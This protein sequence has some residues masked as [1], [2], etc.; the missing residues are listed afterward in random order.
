M[1]A[2]AATFLDYFQFHALTRP[3]QMALRLTGRQLCYR[4]VY[5]HLLR[6]V[7]V[8]RE[9]GWGRERVRVT[10]CLQDSYAQV[11]VPMACEVLGLPYGWQGS[12]HMPVSG[13]WLVSRAEDVPADVSAWVLDDGVWATV[14]TGAPVADGDRPLSSEGNRE[15]VRWLA[16]EAGQREP[17][18]I[19]RD[20]A[21]QRLGWTV[22]DGQFCQGDL[23][24]L[25]SP[26]NDEFVQHWVQAGLS[27]GAC[28]QLLDDGGRMPELSRI[29]GVA[30]WDVL[31]ACSSL[32]WPEL[33]GEVAGRALATGGGAHL[34]GT[35]VEQVR[36]AWTATLGSRASEAI[37]VSL[38]TEVCGVI[39]ARV[40]ADGLALLAPQLR[41]TLRPGSSD[42]DAA[43]LWVNSPFA[44][45]PSGGAD[46][47]AGL[48]D[49]G[50]LVRRRA[51]R[52]M[53]LVS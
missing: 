9:A 34:V 3:D 48:W 13:P 21:Q 51:D 40:N 53:E 7:Q 29:E 42:Q 11:L 38:A 39:A 18:T 32:Q 30:R 2:P 14:L 5:R 33:W 49:T 22:I 26:A 4:D 24:R 52:L 43:G 8:M 20:V 6:L 47:L 35:T 27:V 10:L 44:A 25:W 15:Q 1:S 31:S 17:W 36:T 41:V 46:A 12:A 37:R 28:V 19:P 16:P 50:L 23:L 45:T